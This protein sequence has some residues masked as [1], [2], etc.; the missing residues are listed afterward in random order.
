MGGLGLGEVRPCLPRRMGFGCC[1]GG[2]WDVIPGDHTQPQNKETI[3]RRALGVA[4]WVGEFRACLVHD[5]RELVV[6]LV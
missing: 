6:D 2:F 5:R 1:V 4:W 3:G